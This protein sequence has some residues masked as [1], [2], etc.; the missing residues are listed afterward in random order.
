MSEPTYS[1]ED[2][3]LFTDLYEAAG[4]LGLAPCLI[5]AG[6]IQLRGDG[7]WRIRLDR[8]TKDWDFAVR[9]DSWREFDA[10][11]RRLLS[12]RFTPTDVPHRFL[13]EEGVLLDVLPYGGIEDPPGKLTWPQDVTMTTTGMSALDDHH[14]QLQ[15]TTMEL[16]TATVPAIVGL[17][18]LAYLDR[19]PGEV[20]DIQDVHHLLVKAEDVA[21]DSRIETECI[22]RLQSED[23]S[24]GEVGSY[25]LGRDVGATFQTTALEPMLAL[26]DPKGRALDSALDAARRADDRRVHQRQTVVDRFLAHRLGMLDR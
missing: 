20:R 16:R 18:L 3:A 13:H 8:R 12:G 14:H 5:G 9:V 1:S 21:P 6:A 2:I 19:S 22:R 26:L 24:Y 11:V 23:L 17:K 7:R 15:L 10:L 4:S 25:L